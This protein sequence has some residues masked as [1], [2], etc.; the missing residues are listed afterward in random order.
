[1]R[2]ILFLLA[3]ALSACQPK[4]KPTFRTDDVGRGDVTEAITATG[5][6]EAIQTVSVGTQVSGTVARL[7]VDFN[8]RVHRG[9]L[10]AELDPRLFKAALT[11]AEASV[12]AAEA[13]VEKAK[14]QLADA[15]RT[16]DRNRKLVAKEL[17]A[18]AE[19]DTALAAK[20]AAQAAVKAAQARVQLARAERDTAETNVTLC[21]VRS[22]IDGVVIG[23]ATDVGQTVAASFQSPTLFT[24]A[25]DL[26]RMQIVANIDEADIGKVREEMPARFTVEA[27]PGESFEGRIR[28]V[29]PA[30]T[31]VQNVVTY[32]AVIDAP[33]PDRKL[34]QGMT[35]SVTIAV[36][37]RENVLKLP[38]AALRY[39]PPEDPTAPKSEER[40]EGR[41]KP[42]SAMAVEG[43][44]KPRTATVY[45]LVDGKPAP[46]E[47]TLGLSDGRTTEVLS[48]V[49][50]GDALVVGDSTPRTGGGMG[51]PPGGGQRRGP[52]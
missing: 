29:R 31:T 37:K 26:T 50:E 18:Q 9:Q 14:V 4:A 38:N 41:R 42:E 48:G 32:A 46:L 45:R 8:S 5:A 21:K 13:D 17:V 3:L 24:I 30:P 51:G 33:N 44:R 39:R 52:F 10:L 27:F 35:A 6:V 22:P 1:M 7:F 23:R 12:A 2:P 15:E 19:L 28:E 36:Q 11:R 47:V 49:S 20:E 25:N 34:R 16:L 40:R 43:A